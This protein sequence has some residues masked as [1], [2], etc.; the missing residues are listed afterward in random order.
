MGG[1]EHAKFFG[2]LLPSVGAGLVAPSGERCEGSPLLGSQGRGA[3]LTGGPPSICGVDAVA[4]AG[5]ASEAVSMLGDAVVVRPPNS[6]VS[7]RS[8]RRLG[9][10][11]ALAMRGLFFADGHAGGNGRL[12]VDATSVRALALGWRRT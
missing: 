7:S 4:E 9:C 6:E 2:P 1:D 12:A 11:H 3:A 8:A 10:V 5:K